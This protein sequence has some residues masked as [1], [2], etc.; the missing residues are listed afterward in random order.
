MKS[1]ILNLLKKILLKD[2]WFIDKIIFFILVAYL[3]VEKLLILYYP[4]KGAKFY[5]LE[6]QAFIT[7]IV[8][9]IGIFIPILYNIE[10]DRKKD[11]KTLGFTLGLTWNELRFNKYIL[12]NIKGNFNL[13]EMTNTIGN[14]SELINMITIKTEGLKKMSD[15]FQKISF[16]GSQNSGA[17]TKYKID[18][19]FN[20]VI[21]AYDDITAIQLQLSVLHSDLIVKKLT[22]KTRLIDLQPQNII[23]VKEYLNVRADYLKNQIDMTIRS[24]EESIKLLNSRLDSMNIKAEEVT[25]PTLN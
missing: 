17:I 14:F 23:E 20:T 22:T 4:N 2:Y 25:I 3:V 12:D 10:V 21:K 16:E 5:E 18:D 6:A 9:F 7:F 11:K 8:T 19:D 1:K 15:F 13:K 24:I